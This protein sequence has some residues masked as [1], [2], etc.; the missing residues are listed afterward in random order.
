MLNIIKM[1][2][3]LALILGVILNADN[4][5]TVKMEAIN[6]ST[7]MQIYKSSKHDVRKIYKITD[8]KKAK[9][10]LVGVV[11]FG[12]P[13]KMEDTPSEPEKMILKVSTKTGKLLDKGTSNNPIWFL[14]YYPN[15]NY[16]S[17]EREYETDYGFDLNNA[18]KE[19]GNPENTYDSPTGLYRI[20]GAYN[21]E[22]C[23]GYKLMI[24]V[25][26]Q[27]KTLFNFDDRACYF[28]DKFWK[29]DNN[30]YF[31]IKIEEEKGNSWKYYHIKIK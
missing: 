4:S 12:V 31:S 1:L 18:N 23:Y 26:N 29:D 9:K 5:K 20:T 19:M 11:E 3:G 10:M 6:K 17:V 8:I 14:A 13:K 24:K 16:L 30:F 22:E 21:G 15:E 2:I 25:D 7:Y 27:F 28:T